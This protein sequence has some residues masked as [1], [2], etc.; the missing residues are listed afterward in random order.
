MPRGA[1]CLLVERYP[2]GPIK[3]IGIGS[4]NACRRS[5]R[6]RCDDSV[7]YHSLTCVGKPKLIL[8][9]LEIALR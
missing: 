9:L 2:K 7:L 1:M 4:Q 6:S 8:V 5:A 3:L